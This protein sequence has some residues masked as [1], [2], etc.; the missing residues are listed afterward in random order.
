MHAINSNVNNV[1]YQKNAITIMY[2]HG[3]FPG[4]VLVKY[5]NKERLIQLIP[6]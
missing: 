6:K 4:Y 2:L 1:K 3:V 5:I